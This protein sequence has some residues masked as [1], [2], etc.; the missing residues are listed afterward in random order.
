MA[1]FQTNK[2]KDWFSHETEP[3]FVHGDVFKGVSRNSATLKIE[4][5]ATIGNGRVYNQRKVVFTCFCSNSTIFIG[6]IKTG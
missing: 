2:K 3:V 1:T 6:N 5:F 4:L